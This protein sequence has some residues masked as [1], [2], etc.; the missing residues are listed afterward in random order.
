MCTVW[1]GG[2]KNY[3]LF[4]LLCIMGVKF[5]VD[6]SNLILNTPTYNCLW[7]TKIPQLNFVYVQDIRCRI[8]DEWRPQ[9]NMAGGQLS[10]YC[11]NEWARGRQRRDL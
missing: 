4:K 1:E 10:R 3:T 11:D 2:D 8:F 6:S 5:G 9:Q 7:L